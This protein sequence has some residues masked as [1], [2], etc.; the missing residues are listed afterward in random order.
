MLGTS[1]YARDL[2]LP[3][4]DTSRSAGLSHRRRHTSSRRSGRC[5]RQIR[6]GNRGENPDLTL[7]DVLDHRSNLKHLNWL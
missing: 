5:E 2:A 3:G 1:A 7:R 4:N 6:E